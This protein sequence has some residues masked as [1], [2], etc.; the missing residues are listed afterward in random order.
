MLRVSGYVLVGMGVLLLVGG[1]LGMDDD[2]GAESVSMP[3]TFL[4]LGVLFLLSGWKRSEIRERGL[5]YFGP[6]YQVGA[7]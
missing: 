3:L 1:F 6:L 2:P 4:S 5:F 7:S